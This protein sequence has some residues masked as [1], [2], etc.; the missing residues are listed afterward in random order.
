M[1]L[2]GAGRTR[3]KGKM[4]LPYSLCG[5]KLCSALCTQ[6]TAVAGRLTRVWRVRLQPER[7]GRGARAAPPSGLSHLGCCEL[8]EHLGEEMVVPS[9]RLSLPR[10]ESLEGLKVH[11]SPRCGAMTRSGN[12][13]RSPAMP[14]GR[15]RMHGGTSPGAPKGE[16]NGAYKHGRFTNEAIARRRG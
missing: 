10:I 8:S 7:R 15:C 13:C 1:C 5:M 11:L 16:R 2:S 3:V 9:G 12:P 14:N 4:R 6:M